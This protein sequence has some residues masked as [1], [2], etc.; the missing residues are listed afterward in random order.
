ML[1]ICDKLG[2]CLALEAA[3]S[4]KKFSGDRI[5][6]VLCK[7]HIHRL[8]FAWRKQ[9]AAGQFI[10]NFIGFKDVFLAGLV[11]AFSSATLPAAADVN[12]I[13][14]TQEEDSVN[15]PSQY[16][17][18]P[19]PSAPGE[20]SFLR[21]INPPQANLAD[22]TAYRDFLNR[23]GTLAM[24]QSANQAA[25]V[26]GQFALVDSVV[27]NAVTVNANGVIGSIIALKNGRAE[28]GRSCVQYQATT[29]GQSFVYAV[30]RA[31]DGKMSF[32]NR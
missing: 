9:Q 20:I 4:A 18:P 24:R 14:T 17:L 21:P 27:P 29:A 2:I 3:C 8:N 6:L 16:Q 25:L 5:V 28:D 26:A 31:P 22:V 32:L 30:C 19:I 13:K 15:L 7:Y 23:A 11:L 10:P 1:I 12:K